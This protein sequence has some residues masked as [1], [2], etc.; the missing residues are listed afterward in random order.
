MSTETTMTT[1]ESREERK[2]YLEQERLRLNA[3]WAPVARSLPTNLELGTVSPVYQK[4][5]EIGIQIDQVEVELAEIAL[6]ESEERCEEYRA[7][8]DPAADDA[9]VAEAR[10][11]NKAAAQA[12]FDALRAE[13]A[14]IVR[15]SGRASD[16]REREQ[17]VSNA[18]ARLAKWRETLQRDQATWSYGEYRQVRSV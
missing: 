11:R 1:G 18:E 3:A 2:A 15:R 10:K 7:T 5:T 16:L 9:A 14:A 13:R 6:Q 12:A 8:Y 4:R 17:A